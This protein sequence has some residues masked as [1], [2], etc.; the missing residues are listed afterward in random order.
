MGY[1][2]LAAKGLLR[3]ALDELGVGPAADHEHGVHVVPD[4]LRQV[5][6]LGRH[7]PV[8][9]PQPADAGVPR[10][11]RRPLRR[12]TRRCGPTP[13][14]CSPTTPRACS[15]RACSGRR[16]VGPR[17][18]GRARAD[19]LPAE[20]HRRR[21]TRTSPA[22]PTSTAC[23]TATGSSTAGSPTASSS[24]RASS[25][26]GSRSALAAMSPPRLPLHHRAQRSGEQR[27][28][29]APSPPLFEL[30]TELAGH[31]QRVVVE[32]DD[33][34]VLRAVARVRPCGASTSWCRRTSRRRPC[35]AS[36][37]APGSAPDAA[38]ATMPP[39]R[40]RH[41]S[42]PRRPPPRPGEVGTAPPPPTPTPVARHTRRAARACAAGAMTGA[43]GTAHA[44]PAAARAP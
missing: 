12:P 37:G 10:A 41:H 3:E 31:P 7:R 35:P 17:A 8:R 18:Q 28:D 23:S 16:P 9:P 15:S 11:L 43:A 6:G 13:S 39:P 4:G 22:R 1:G 5:R 44:R 32:V 26:P 2:M 33:R 21:R 38:T 29:R 34:R 25:S 30:G 42:A 14:R 40:S 24:S 19:P 20:H 27:P 36:S